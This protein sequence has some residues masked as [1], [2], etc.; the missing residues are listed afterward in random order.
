[1]VDKTPEQRALEKYN[2]NLSAE[3]DKTFQE[4][5]KSHSG[6]SLLWW[7]LQIGRVNLQPF[8]SSAER[9]AFNCGELNVGNQILAKLIE[10][11]PEG[12]LSMMK[13]KQSERSA[14]NDPSNNGTGSGSPGAYD[15]A[16]AEP[17]NPGAA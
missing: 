4:L 5:T 15:D 6:R 12:Y 2:A 10:V 13:E 16:A 9:T 1:M 17:D 3:V 8:S 11:S 14:L 7:L